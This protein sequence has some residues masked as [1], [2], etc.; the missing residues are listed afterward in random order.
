MAF[1]L[2]LFLG[3][4]VCLF[5]GMKYYFSKK[6]NAGLLKTLEDLKIFPLISSRYI[7]VNKSIH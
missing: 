2:L 6:K 1:C 4:V 5:G 3:F 7:Q